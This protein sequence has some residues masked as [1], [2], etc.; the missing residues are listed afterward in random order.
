MKLISKIILIVSILMVQ[1]SCIER[2]KKTTENEIIKAVEETT[3]KETKEEPKDSVIQSVTPVDT[4]VKK[5]EP[6]VVAPETP[7][8]SQP[9]RQTTSTY[10]RRDDD[11]IDRGNSGF[12]DEYKKDYKG[13]PNENLKPIVKVV[14]SKEAIRQ[15]EVLEKK[16]DKLEQ[17]NQEQLENQQRINKAIDEYNQ[18]AIEETKAKQEEITKPQGK[19]LDTDLLLDNK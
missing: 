16:I 11:R 9:A 15:K 10:T 5:E 19:T 12:F 7:K 8:T 14:E 2:A 18:K 1:I 17:I 3:I 4:I 13:D 6:P